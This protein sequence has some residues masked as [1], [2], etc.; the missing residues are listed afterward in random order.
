[1]DPTKE[2][3][4]ERVAEYDEIGDKAF[5]AKYANNRPPIKNYVLEKGKLYP[6]KALYASSYLPPVKPSRLN[7]KF[8]MSRLEKL[9][10]ECIV[11]DDADLFVEGRRNVQE[12]ETIARNRNLVRAARVAHGYDCAACGFNFGS[13]Y[14]DI[15]KGFIECHHLN[16]VS[17]AGEVTL[18]VKDVAVLCSNCH[19]MVHTSE[20][21]LTIDRLRE[22]IAQ[23]YCRGTMSIV[24]EGM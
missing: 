3:I 14:G 15:G 20:P 4:R 5:L 11:D 19:H 21:P 12:I 10:F 13:F 1:M 17:S 8:I 16:P 6:L 7:P 2:S 24:G 23:N 18:S 9:G 22:I